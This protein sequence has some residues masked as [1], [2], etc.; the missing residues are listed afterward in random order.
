M[1][2][3]KRGKNGE[4]VAVSEGGRDGGREG[5]NKEG[6]KKDLEGSKNGKGKQ[7]GNRQRWTYHNIHET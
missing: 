6:K 5:R 1:E 3:R 2:G 4:R 7:T